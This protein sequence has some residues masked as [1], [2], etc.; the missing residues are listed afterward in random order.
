MAETRKM[1]EGGGDN[2]PGLLQTLLISVE[3]A[4]ER[5]PVEN[6]AFPCPKC[7]EYFELDNNA[8]DDALE[9]CECGCSAQ[10]K[11]VE[12]RDSCIQTS[13]MFEIVGSIP[14]IDSDEEDDRHDEETPEVMSTECSSGPVSTGT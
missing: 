11:T 6:L 13:P 2:L 3:D 1:D 12:K 4:I 7:H 9:N 8:D 10:P 5:V 14:H